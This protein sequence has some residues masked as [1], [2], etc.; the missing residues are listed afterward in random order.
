MDK[1]RIR[2]P[3]PIERKNLYEQLTSI[4]KKAQYD[5]YES[6]IIALKL[7]GTPKPIKDKQAYEKMVSLLIQAGYAEPDAQ[8]TAQKVLSIET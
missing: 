1:S 3:D 2:I 7:L 6:E 8:V 4:L 5:E